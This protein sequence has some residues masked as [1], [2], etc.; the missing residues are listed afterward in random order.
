MIFAPDLAAK[1]TQGRKTVTRRP[2][3]RDRDGHTLACTYKPGRTYAVQLCRGGS[4]VDRIG[5][6]S[7]SRETVEFPLTYTETAAEGFDRPEQFEARWRDLYGADGPRDV[8][9]IEFE[10]LS[11]IE[12]AMSGAENSQAQPDD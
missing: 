4:E 2:V 10:A 3:K 9:R 11:L 8:W 5:I 6:I 12:A 1:I 7:V